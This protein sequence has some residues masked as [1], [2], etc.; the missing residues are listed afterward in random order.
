MT[1]S[2]RDPTAASAERARVGARETRSPGHTCLGMSLGQRLYSQISRVL[3][4][5]GDK[6][7]TQGRR[8]C[9]RESSPEEGKYRGTMLLSHPTNEKK[10]FPNIKLHQTP[11]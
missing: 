6:R 10:M 5:D 1:L 9:C 7:P 3:L 4:H 2:C 11:P 8:R